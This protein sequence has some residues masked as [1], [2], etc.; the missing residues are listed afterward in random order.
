[1]TCPVSQQIANHVNVDEG[2]C[3][4]CEGY[5]EEKCATYGYWLECEQCGW[6]TDIEEE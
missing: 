3:P 2:L 5:L 4:E 1:M 6:S